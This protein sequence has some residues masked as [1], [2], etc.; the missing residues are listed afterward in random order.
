MHISRLPP[1]DRFIWTS[2]TGN[3][4]TKTVSA[5]YLGKR[6]KFQ[7]PPCRCRLFTN[8]G[9]HTVYITLE[10]EIQSEF[11]RLVEEYEA[12]VVSLVNP[13]GGLELSSSIKSSEQYTSFRLTVWEAQWF[14]ESGS[15]LRDAPGSMTVCSCILEF[16]GAWVGSTSFG[17]KFKALQIKAEPPGTVRIPEPVCCLLDDD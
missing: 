6:V 2:P 7:L 8:Q 11:R 17:L 3:G 9:S 15:F 5:T 10:N 1:A 14:D 12:Y 16:Q 4:K 13:D